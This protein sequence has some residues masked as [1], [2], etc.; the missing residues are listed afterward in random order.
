M[1][2]VSPW[3]SAQSQALGRLDEDSFP[4]QAFSRL[5]FLPPHSLRDCLH[6][7]PVVCPGCGAV[8]NRR[9]LSAGLSAPVEPCPSPVSQL[10]AGRGQPLHII[11]C[12]KEDL[13]FHVSPASSLIL[14]EVVVSTRQQGTAFSA[15][16]S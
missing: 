7:T 15:R 9:L 10:L 11:L 8:C 5:P 2:S 6:L 16:I 4:D 1:K 14:H 3:L 13:S 12:L